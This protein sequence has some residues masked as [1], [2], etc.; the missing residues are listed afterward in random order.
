[1]KNGPTARS[2]WP[3]P[4]D[5]RR[6]ARLARRPALEMMEPRTMLSAIVVNTLSD[7]FDGDGRRDQPCQ[8]IAQ[9]ASTSGDQTITFAGYLSGPVELAQGPLVLADSSGSLT[10]QATSGVTTIDAGGASEVLDVES[11][12]TATLDGLTITGGSAYNGGGIDN[13]GR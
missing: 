6:R 8:A 1:M 13:S 11:G 12:T 10:I 5:S 9:A 2:R 4:L 3:R 7:P